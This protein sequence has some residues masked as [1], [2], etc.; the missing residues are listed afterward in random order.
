MTRE[1]AANDIAIVGLAGRF[2]GARTLADFWR[3]LREGVESIS[4]VA[5]EECDAVPLEPDV[6]HDPNFV[7]A[8]A[9]LDGIEDFDA[10]LFGFTPAE[11]MLTDPQHRVFLECAWEALEN[12][13]FDPSRFPG[14]T[15]VYAGTTFSRYLYHCLTRGDLVRQ[16]GVD[17]IAMG[18]NLDFMTTLASY[19]LNLRGPSY[20][21]QTACSSSLVAVHVAAQALI[22]GECDMALAGG[23]AIRVPQRSGY[24]Y[25]QGGVLSPDGHC[26]PFDA[27]AA[28]TVFTNGAGVVLLQRLEDAMEWGSPIRAIIR[29]SAVNNDGSAKAGFTAPGVQGQS[30]V[31]AEALANSGISAESIGYVE[32]H[33]TGTAVGDPIE[34]TA[35][36]EAFRSANRKTGGCALGSVKSNIGHLDAASGVAGLI[37]TVL[38]LEHR[39]IPP[40]VHF[41]NPNPRIDFAAS[42]FCV[43]SELRPWNGSSESP[44][45]AGVS[46][47]GIG[48]TNAH[49]ILEEAAESVPGAGARR[50][51]LLVASAQ[52]GTARDEAAQRLR[53]AVRCHTV[54]ELADAAYTMQMGRK[55]LP[56]RWAQV[57]DANGR[58]LGEALRGEAR[59]CIPQAACDGALARV[60]TA[61]AEAFA[62]VGRLWVR[63][64]DVPW[65]TLY[66]GQRRK[67][68]PLP[69]YPFQ[70]RRYWVEGSAGGASA[71]GP[72]R[73]PFDEWFYVPSWK[74]SAPPVADASAPDRQW[75][76]FVGGQALGE[77]VANLLEAAGHVIRV[78][79]GDTFTAG[80]D[81]Q[82][83]IRI[84]H[85][86]DYE[87]LLDAL[88]AAGHFPDD[89]VD[90]RPVSAS[91]DGGFYSLL[92]LAQA[93]APRSRARSVVIQVVTSAAFEITG[94]EEVRPAAGMIAG[95]CKVIPQEYSNISCR[96]ID[97]PR[98]DGAMTGHWDKTIA[99]EARTRNGPA[100]VAFRGRH[101]WIPC[102]QQ[103]VPQSLVTA[104]LRS[105]PGGVYLIIGGLGR[106][107]LM[108]ARHLSRQ[109]QARIFLT[110]RSPFPAP[111]GWQ[112]WIE[113]HPADD[114]ISMR[115]QALESLIAGGA[116]V[117]VLTADAADERQMADAIR[118]A[119]TESGPLRGIIHAAGIIGEQ[120][121]LGIHATSAADCEKVF[122]A[123]V[124]GLQ[125]LACIL[126]KECP[127]LEFALLTSSLSPILGGLGLAAYAAAHH[128]MDGFAE[129]MHRSSPQ[130]MSVNW[131]GWRRDRAQVAGEGLGKSLAGLAMSDEEVEQCLD[132]VLRMRLPRVVIATAGLAERVRQWVGAAAAND[133]ATTGSPPDDLATVELIILQ[134]AR[135]ILG[136]PELGPHDDLFE[137]GANSLSAVQIVSRLR[138][139]LRGEIPLAH[140]FVHPSAA[141]LAAALT[142]GTSAGADT[143]L[144]RILTEVEGLD[145]EEARALLASET[146]TG[147]EAGTRHG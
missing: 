138:Q 135:S 15:G 41:R 123:K 79:S 2:P 14:V 143:E 45:R 125:S 110:S 8:V 103:A 137:N 13:G 68:V 109:P 62:E 64:A 140:L 130:W 107:G 58:F 99:A 128:F 25:E 67:R 43:N 75:L 122:G 59:E 49:V 46:S 93:L 120:T 100:L 91:G 127:N 30:S 60:A 29:A 54:E 85:R 4:I 104:S 81:G 101:R 108:A 89:I 40:T 11:A 134:V 24:R 27:L 115:I 33:G 44:R 18:N 20:A 12:A 3:N 42:P 145:P 82:F 69:G 78:A 7:A 98:L 147:A 23:V 144:E 55:A 132:L 131:E 146:Q 94:D 124:H 35:L 28:G 102:F 96:H 10:A 126:A 88:D 48:G 57:V 56:H 66:R 61:E 38:M 26:R 83:T 90:C 51:H 112:R 117:R 111:S 32:A 21:V 39:E 133:G 84:G 80:G 1:P 17:L 119:Q 77:E 105:R 76:I 47:F 116:S 95:P 65:E 141:Q 139:Q 74:R 113:T 142:S 70:R 34:V 87:A 121:H 114:P 97:L 71:T 53:D 118:S 136:T 31:I 73:R 37:K 22:A 16:H 106:F 5:P 63:G 72:Q 52:T 6:R 86:S 19:K 129:Q 92:Y 36:T 9:P 50:Y